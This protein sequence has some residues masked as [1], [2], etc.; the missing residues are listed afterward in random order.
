MRE[1]SQAEESKLATCDDRLQLLVRTVNGE[2]PL[3][4]VYGH[5]SEVEQE[6]A[7][8]NGFS[9]VHFPNSKHNS[10]PSKAVDLAPWP[11]DWNNTARF[12]ELYHKVMEVAARLGIKLRAG[13]DFNED[14]D[15]TNDRFL[16]LPH[17]E[18]KGE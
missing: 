5:R 18:L 16:D 8:V 1:F 14:G 6:K 9:K 7:V 15:L 2:F 12:R 17:Y 4:V 13:A 11:L 3:L 10:L